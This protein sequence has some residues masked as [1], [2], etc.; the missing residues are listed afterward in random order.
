MPE[1]QRNPGQLPIQVLVVDDSAVVRQALTAILGQERDMRVVTAQD[2]I[3]ALQK[4]Q[5]LR[6]DVIVLDLEMPRMDGIT[7]LRRLMKDDPLPVVICS[8][9]AAR[10]AE[11]AMLALEEGA[12][13]VITKPK[14]GVRDFLH[15]SAMQII[16]TVR[17]AAHSRL[18]RRR[19]APQH[20]PPLETGAPVLGTT[21][22]QVVV[23]GA[24]TGGTEALRELLSAMP[25]DCAGIVVV[26][27]M[28]ELF[29]AAFAK[30]LNEVCRIEV[31]EAADGD[32]I[33]VGRALIAPGNRHTEVARSGGRYVVRVSDGPL[34]SR[35][36]P[37]VD[38]LFHSAARAAGSNG[39]GVIMTGMGDDGANGMLEMKRA[40]AYNLAQD[41]ATC[42]VYG[43]PKEAVDRGG[44][45]AVVPLQALPKAIL[46]AVRRGRR[47]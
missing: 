1:L 13:S 19:A 8:S 30:R 41:E 4:M 32:G 10:G 47:G 42:V 9:L 20:R 46:D 40:G 22:D 45:D 31:K 15:E 16:D 28:P 39:V 18:R 3:F 11:A 14:L 12:L 23:V 43:M 17:A 6:P 36:R 5:T 26:Q 25:V 37:S 38:V 29:T 2:P 35:H 44:V 24:S 7:F 33:L 34:V 21:T 27:H